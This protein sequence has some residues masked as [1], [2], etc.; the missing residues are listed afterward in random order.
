MRWRY[1]QT[2]F[3]N[4]SAQE[5]PSFV[6]KK[7]K[8]KPR[9]VV[10]TFGAPPKLQGRA[11]AMGLRNWQEDLTAIVMYWLPKPQDASSRATYAETPYRLGGWLRKTLQDTPKRSTPYIMTDLND[12]M[13]VT[14]NDDENQ[15]VTGDLLPER[16]GLAASLFRDILQES[17]DGSDQHSPCWRGNPR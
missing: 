12:R 2:R 10:R 7:K 11:G 13:G 8:R 15:A 17:R 14:R 3:S 5:C 4:M 1:E 6:S 16:E 9:H